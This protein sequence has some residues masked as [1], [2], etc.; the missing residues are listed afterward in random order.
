MMRFFAIAIFATVSAHGILAQPAATLPAFE[1]S[2]IKRS[3][4][5]ARD[6]SFPIIGTRF[7]SNNNTL[8]QC[9][10]LAYNLTLRLI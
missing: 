10:G 8:K 7:M 1:V 9:I 5:D 3:S 4:P 2:T 6:R